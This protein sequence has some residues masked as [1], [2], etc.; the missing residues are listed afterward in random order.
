M[1]VK[2]YEDR[3]FEVEEVRI[4]VRAPPYLT[5]GDYV[6]AR[7][8]KGS[9]TISAWLETRVVHGVNGHEVEVID[10]CGGT[11]RRNTQMDN[12]R[13]SYDH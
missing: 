3:V 7:K 5:I 12:L 4:V 9:N 10:G 13:E 1:L 11:P 6:Y 2:E 8:Y